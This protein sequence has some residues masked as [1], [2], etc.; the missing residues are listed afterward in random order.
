M[1][2]AVSSPQFGGRTD[3]P[4]SYSEYEDTRLNMVTTIQ[5]S[6]TDNDKDF[7]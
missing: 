5:K 6:I 1:L 7:F 2:P 4:F 3:E